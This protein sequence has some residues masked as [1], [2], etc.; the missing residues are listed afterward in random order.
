MQEKVTADPAPYSD[1]STWHMDA[2]K[3]SAVINQFSYNEDIA[4]MQ[5]YMGSGLAQV[6]D[7][8]DFLNMRKV[9]KEPWFLQFAESNEAFL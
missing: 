3:L 7:N 8:G 2:L 9:E 4:G 5:L 1:V 6:T